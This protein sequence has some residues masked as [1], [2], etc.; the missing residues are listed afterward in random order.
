M[1]PPLIRILGAEDA[2]L[3][4]AHGGPRMFFNIED[5]LSKSTGVVNTQFQVL[6]LA[7]VIVQ[8]K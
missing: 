5:H 6:C 4:N 2:Y 8:G 1:I 7:I 3:S